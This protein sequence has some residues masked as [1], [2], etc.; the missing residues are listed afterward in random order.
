MCRLGVHLLC[1]PEAFLQDSLLSPIAFNVWISSNFCRKGQ[2]GTPLFLISL[3]DAVPWQPRRVWEPLLALWGPR[4]LSW[5]GGSISHSICACSPAYLP[6]SLPLKSVTW[7]LRKSSSWICLCLS[8][9]S[10]RIC[11]L[12]CRSEQF[13]GKGCGVGHRYDLGMLCWV[14]LQLFCVGLALSCSKLSPC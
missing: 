7:G 14:V 1:V 9:S 6:G 5:Q 2:G 13:G 8:S 3:G 4:E 11:C 10:G 12:R